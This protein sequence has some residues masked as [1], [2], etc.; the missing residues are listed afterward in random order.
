M[1]SPTSDP[2]A[3]RPSPGPF[4]DSCR[5]HSL[6]RAWAKNN[7]PTNSSA[8]ELPSTSTQ[9]TSLASALSSLTFNCLPVRANAAQ[10][11]SG[12][13]VLEADLEATVFPDGPV[14]CAL[15]EVFLILVDLISVLVPAARGE[16]RLRRNDRQR[17]SA[18]RPRGARPPWRVSASARPPRTA[19]GH[20]RRPALRTANSK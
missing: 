12:V 16:V 9:G 20:S 18:A 5:P 10:S 17:R 7:R 13:G 14:S 11:A 2:L 1:Y 15:L 8:I 6:L 19:T 3:K 4:G